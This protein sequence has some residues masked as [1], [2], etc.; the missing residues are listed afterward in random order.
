LSA[1]GPATDDGVVPRWVVCACIVAGSVALATTARAHA[2]PADNLNNR[3]LK[4]TPMGDRVRVAYTVVF[5]IGPGTVLRRR[6]DRDHD[7]TISDAES[8]TI[9]RELAT[10]V[11]ATLGFTLDG[12]A[13]LWR[14][15]R[16][17]VGLG[18][19][20]VNGG[21]MS[22]DLIAWL[23]TGGG[24]H[25]FT[26]RDDY[27]LAEAGSTELTVE[28]GPGIHIVGRTLGGEPMSDDVATWNGRGGP[29]ATGA[30]I[31]F[32]TDDR[33]TRPHDRRCRNVRGRSASRAPLTVAAVIGGAAVAAGLVAWRRRRRAQ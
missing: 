31:E 29:I 11:A 22:V 17:D 1:P 26:M 28:I 20:D 33:A 18:T 9:G 32:T 7:H 6:L 19:A 3:Y 12:Q 4:I 10:E 5:G 21:S 13:M 8:S 30:E 16:V 14:W 24:G 23:C 25:R 15:D 2:P 27:A